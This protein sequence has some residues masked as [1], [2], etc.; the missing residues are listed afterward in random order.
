MPTTFPMAHV[1]M[2]TMPTACSVPPTSPAGEEGIPNAEVYKHFAISSK[3]NNRRAQE[4]LK[5]FNIGVTV[6]NSGRVIQNR[7]Q[8]PHQLLTAYKQRQEARRAAVLAPA[9]TLAAAAIPGLPLLT[10]PGMPGHATQADHG[11]AA[12]DVDLPAAGTPRNAAALLPA[13]GSAQRGARAATPPAAGLPPRPPAQ[14][15]IANADQF[16]GMSGANME[17]HRGGSFAFLRQNR[18]GS[19]SVW[20]QKVVVRCGGCVLCD[21]CCCVPHACLHPSCPKRG[22][23]HHTVTSQQCPVTP[24]L[25]LQRLCNTTLCLTCLQRLCNTTLCLAA[26]RPPAA[27]RACSA[28]SPTWLS[29]A[30]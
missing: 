23:R 28:C 27:T 9:P 5:R 2:Y 8:A 12:M 25:S 21:V 6:E 24:E 7:L 4:L 29:M 17:G 18:R 3:T 30:S 1:D 16:L 22:W 14:P 10:A 19:L 13:P 20:R 11:T 15:I 26:C